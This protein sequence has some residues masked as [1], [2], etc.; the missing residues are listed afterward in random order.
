MGLTFGSLLAGPRGDKQDEKE[1]RAI[2]AK[3]QA[4]EPRALN[5]RELTEDLPPNER[6]LLRYVMNGHSI[7]QCAGHLGMSLE[8]A[9]GLKA[10]LMRKLNA[11]RTADLVQIALC[12]GFD[13]ID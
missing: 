2:L 3:S 13:A 5:A 10:A 12:A 4:A 8:E 1:G 7:V 11:T 6:L 9:S